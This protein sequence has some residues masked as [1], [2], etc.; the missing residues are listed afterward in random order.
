MELRD[1]P[2]SRHT[3]AEPITITYYHDVMKYYLWIKNELKPD[4]KSK[5]PTV[6]EI[7]ERVAIK[8]KGNPVYFVISFGK[9]R[10]QN[11][12]AKQTLLQ[13]QQQQQ[14]KGISQTYALNRFTER[15]VPGI[16]SYLHMILD[17]T[18]F[19][20]QQIFRQQTG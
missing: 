6:G 4:F 9:V 7:S 17:V 3:G 5:E 18:C 2:V 14:Q 16:T 8:N 20:D 19:D 12:A 1:I 13:Q 15:L 11:S 10:L